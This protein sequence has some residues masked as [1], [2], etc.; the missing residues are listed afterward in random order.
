M[1]TKTSPGSID[2]DLGVTVRAIKDE[3]LASVRSQIKAT[4]VDARDQISKQREACIKEVK[5][6]L[7]DMLQ[8][9]LDEIRGDIESRLEG[10]VRKEIDVFLKSRYRELARVLESLPPPTIHLDIPTRS[11]VKHIEYEDGRPVTII[12]ETLE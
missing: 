5:K 1:V 8:A 12:E 2:M 4:V 3:V 7:E 6:V 9:G 10:I 11:V